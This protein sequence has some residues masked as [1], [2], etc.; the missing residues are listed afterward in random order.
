MFRYDYARMLGTC[1]FATLR[2]PICGRR[3]LIL[4]CMH[5]IR[6]VLTGFA[7]LALLQSFFRKPSHG[8]I[9]IPRDAHAR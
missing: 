4:S 2:D 1:H 8:Y 9:R 6:G 3:L 7:F 5:G